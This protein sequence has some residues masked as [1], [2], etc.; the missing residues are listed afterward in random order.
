M[1]VGIR[2]SK[3]KRPKK[4]PFHVEARSGSG[5]PADRPRSE[6]QS[7][8]F[9]ARRREAGPERGTTSRWLRIRARTGGTFESLNPVGLPVHLPGRSVASSAIAGATGPLPAIAL[10]GSAM[11]VHRHHAGFQAPHRN[12]RFVLRRT[13]NS[14]AAG[15]EHRAAEL[16]DLVRRSQSAR[17]LAHSQLEEMLAILQ[18]VEA[19]GADLHRLPPD[20][21]AH[22]H[23]VLRAGIRSP[24]GTGFFLPPMSGTRPGS[25]TS[26]LDGAEASAR[27]SRDPPPALPRGLNE[28]EMRSLQVV[29]APSHTR[30][31]STGSADRRQTSPGRRGPSPG[32]TEREDDG[33]DVCAV[34]ISQMA[35]GEMV[36]TLACRHR[37]HHACIARWLRISVACPLCK[38]HAL[39]R[40]NGAA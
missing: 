13:V 16:H 34:C 35:G 20:R 29:V 21:L 40:S 4:R 27:G 10:G 15:A 23:R 33:D 25:G 31:S 11:I 37:F 28:A 22:I 36:C 14:V 1:Q 30:V 3:N 8:A 7:G 19:A 26:A 24:S 6:M 32:P 12:S 2:M 17:A 38:A 18:E 39:G 9:P 5:G